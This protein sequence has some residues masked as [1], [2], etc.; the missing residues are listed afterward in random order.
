MAA[1]IAPCRLLST[2][3]SGEWRVSRH[4]QC[5]CQWHWQ[6]Q[7]MSI[8]VPGAQWCDRGPT[9]RGPA[10]AGGQCILLL[11]L[12]S[13]ACSTELPF[14][15][16]LESGGHWRIAPGSAAS[17]P[18]QEAWVT[19]GCALRAWSKDN[20]RNRRIAIVG[21][22][23]SRFLMFDLAATMFRCPPLVDCNP[24]TCN[25]GVP[26]GV[27]RDADSLR[28][29]CASLYQYTYVTRLHENLYLTDPKLNAS[30]D[31][32]WISYAEEFLRHGWVKP[33]FVNPA[34]DAF[35]VS[36][37]LW[38]VGVKPKPGLDVTPSVAH[39]CAWMVSHVKDMF[40]NALF[41]ANPSLQRNVLYWTTSY[42]EPYRN[43]NSPTTEYER[44]PH[45]QLDTVNRCSRMTFR[46]ALGTAFFNASATVRAPAP[47]LAGMLRASN[48]STP[49]AAAAAGLKDASRLLTLDGYHPNRLTRAAL[50]DEI[51]NYYVSLWGP[52]APAPPEGAEGGG[53]SAGSAGGERRG[54]GQG[55]GQGE[56]AAAASG[57]SSRSSAGPRGELL[58]PGLL[59]RPAGAMRGGAE[60]GLSWVAILGM[61]VVVGVGGLAIMRQG[62]GGP[63]EASP[64][65][66]GSRGRGGARGEGAF[67]F[68]GAGSGASA[69]SSSSSGGGSGSQASGK[70]LP[71]A[72]AR[73]PSTAVSGKGKAG[74]AGKAF[75]FY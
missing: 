15:T 11:L 24:T 60:E 51:M 30:L 28:E 33:L 2:Q 6:W 31:L 14:C 70:A 22:S 54:E 47:L 56:G 72:W 73:E 8:F 4:W 52:A 9:H 61:A 34:Y 48:A 49:A 55:Q 50:L 5:H 68:G 69:P 45:D 44:F 39:H 42:S 13:L 63:F 66:G 74:K 26:E 46:D 10:M 37:G 36:V 3:I 75:Q 67:G 29:P 20:L 32:Y 17:P 57:G 62:G 12:L 27:T 65:E 19:P 38:D 59:G 40:L 16:P 23:V 25:S 1:A 21:D 64:V 41:P 43:P 71:P 58:V 35:I 7:V 18:A 53:S